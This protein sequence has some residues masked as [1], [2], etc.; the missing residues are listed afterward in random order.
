[1]HRGGWWEVSG[2]LGKAP[3]APERER[4]SS[5]RDVFCLAD[6]V[7]SS[8]PWVEKR[9]V[10]GGDGERGGEQL[11][12]GNKSVANSDPKPFAQMMLAQGGLEIQGIL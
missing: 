4:D 2:F 7:M 8:S 3:P 9:G 1:M 11:V 5:A 12:S 10:T 6:T